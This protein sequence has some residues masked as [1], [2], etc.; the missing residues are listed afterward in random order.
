M[1]TAFILK[2]FLF[3]AVVSLAIKLVASYYVEI[4]PSEMAAI[5]MIFAPVVILG[6]VLWRRILQLES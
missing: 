6:M 1:K 2:V 5:S 4:N 3:S